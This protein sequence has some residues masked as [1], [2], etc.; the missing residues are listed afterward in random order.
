MGYDDGS[1]RLHNFEVRPCQIYKVEARAKPKGGSK[2][3]ATT[4]H[5]IRSVEELK[6]KSFD[7]KN[8]DYRINSEKWIE[9][10]P[11]NVPKQITTQQ[12][13][14]ASNAL[15]THPPS[16]KP[17][18]NVS[19]QKDI[20][21]L[22][23]DELPASPRPDTQ[24]SPRNVIKKIGSGAC[25]STKCR[26]CKLMPTGHYCVKQKKG[27]NTYFSDNTRNEVCGVATCF[28]CR[29]KFG[30]KDGKYMNY[31]IA[32]SREMKKVEIAALNKKRKGKALPKVLPIRKSARGGLKRSNRNQK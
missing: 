23:R 5:T 28:E 19:E 2:R 7:F 14:N 29:S 10:T 3:R 30:D 32:C 8:Y 27:S 24:S 22:V 26:H 20:A 13:R 12:P 21:G 17:S 25:E 1:T 16:D 11:A 9:P 18:S 15:V 31:C 4:T 6:D